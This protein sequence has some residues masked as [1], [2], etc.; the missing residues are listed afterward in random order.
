MPRLRGRRARDARRGSSRHEMGARAKPC[1][2][3]AEEVKM[4]N[5]Y[6]GGEGGDSPLAY[7][8]ATTGEVHEMAWAVWPSL[9]LIQRWSPNV[10]RC[11]AEL[12]FELS[13]SC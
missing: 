9:P 13:R 10:A 2:E 7:A 1:P 4:S 11:I 3:T 5:A 12:D 8:R 6:P